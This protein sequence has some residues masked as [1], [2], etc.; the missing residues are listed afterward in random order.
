M[1]GVLI[2]EDQQ[3]LASALEIA[4]GTQPD[5]DCVGTAAT[6]HEALSQ[7]ALRRHDIVLARNKER[8]IGLT[9]ELQ[10]C[11]KAWQIGQGNPEPLLKDLAFIV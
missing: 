1:T 5:M 7:V 8:G 11:R 4:I 6:V 2:V 10:R 3:V 9:S